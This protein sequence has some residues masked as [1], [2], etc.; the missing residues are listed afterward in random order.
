MTRLYT[1]YVIEIRGFL[2]TVRPNFPS[3]DSSGC[4]AARGAAPDCSLKAH[5]RYNSTAG[6]GA[7]GRRRA[8][9]ISAEHYSC[10]THYR[11]KSN[12][13]LRVSQST[14]K[15]SVPYIVIT[16]DDDG[17]QQP[18]VRPRSAWRT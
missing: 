9:V 10:V 1:R 13:T 8:P 11:V 2:P 14:F 6:S 4:S 5:A 17:L 15:Q 7:G 3:N 12:L 18:S 16:I